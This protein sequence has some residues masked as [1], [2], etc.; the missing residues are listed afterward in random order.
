LQQVARATLKSTT[1]TWNSITTGLLQGGKVSYSNK[2]EAAITKF[3]ALNKPTWNVRY[4]SKSPAL[5]G[6]SKNSWAT[7]ISSGVI[8]GVPTWK[9]KTARP[10]LLELGKKGEVISAYTL[11]A[12]AVVISANN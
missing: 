4:L 3:S 11:S 7:F 8:K 9:P 12:P 10:V 5:V 6:V 2:T 1:R